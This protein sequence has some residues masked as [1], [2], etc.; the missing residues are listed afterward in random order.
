MEWNIEKQNFGFLKIRLSVYFC[1]FSLN[2][3]IIYEK[4]SPKDLNLTTHH[5]GKIFFL[6]NISTN[7]LFRIRISSRLPE[8]S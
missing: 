3:F 1:F 4:K 2:L 5:F 6:K 8:K 7:H